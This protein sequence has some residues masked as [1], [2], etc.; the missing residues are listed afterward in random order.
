MGTSAGNEDALSNLDKFAS[1][2]TEFLELADI[3]GLN[4]IMPYF[5]Q[6]LCTATRKK[7]MIVT[8]SGEI[9]KCWDT[10]TT[11]AESVADIAQISGALIRKISDNKWTNFDASL[12]NNCRNCRLLP[13]CGGNCAIKHYEHY[14]ESEGFHSA[15]PPLK[16]LLGEYLIRR[17]EQSS[18]DLP[19][20]SKNFAANRKIS[21]NALQVSA[22]SSVTIS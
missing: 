13:V 17:V 10:V 22:K 18:Q 9:H 3:N 16:F 15:C 4:G 1:V 6:G 2:Y 5:N 14:G 21:I 12:N 8:P 7:S 20:T 19:Y 11:S